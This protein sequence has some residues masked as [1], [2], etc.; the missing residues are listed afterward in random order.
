MKAVS[1]HGAL[2]TGAVALLLLGGIQG[3]VAQDKSTTLYKIISV[4][5][6]IVIGLNAD[7]L[8]GLASKG[9]GAVAS[10]LAAKGELS[11]WQYAAHKAANGD[12][13]MA[14][15]HKIGLLANSSLRVEPYASP[16]PVLPHE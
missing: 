11:V 14:P 4:K 13:Q 8:D 2:R 7:E 15:L 10:A 1:I 16:I 12:L 9:A 6:D 3:A 5:D